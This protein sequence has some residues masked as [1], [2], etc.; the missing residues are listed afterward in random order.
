MALKAV[1]ETAV[2]QCEENRIPFSQFFPIHIIVAKER[3]ST[4]FYGQYPV[5]KDNG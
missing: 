4:N 1:S 2:S 3:R 5:F